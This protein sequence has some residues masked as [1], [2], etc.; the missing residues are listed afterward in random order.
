MSTELQ[1]KGRG[2]GSNS[3]TD[4]PGSLCFSLSLTPHPVPSMSALEVSVILVEYFQES[5]REV[6]LKW[7]NDLW[8]AERKKCGGI[9]LQGLG[10][11]YLAGIGLNLFS[12]DPSFGGIFSAPPKR[13]KETLAREIASYVLTHRISDPDH[14]RE[15]WMSFCGHRE[16][17]VR[18]IEGDSLSEGTFQGIGEHGEA[19]ILTPEG[20][21]SFYNGSLRLRDDSLGD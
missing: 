4:L 5:G 16:R 14:L 9:L 18:L 15:R 11:L 20:P 8:T 3:W 12:E 17:T 7:P 2:R 10:D 1:S 13:D 19:R 6:K 21:R